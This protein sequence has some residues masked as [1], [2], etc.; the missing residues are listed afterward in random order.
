MPETKVFLYFDFNYVC[1]LC[2]YIVS[3]HQND[4]AEKILAF[5]TTRLQSWLDILE[6]PL[7][8][9]NGQLY[10]FDNRVTCVDLCVFNSVFS[11][12]EYLG[13]YYQRYVVDTHPVLVE[14][15]ARIGK[16]AN[17]AKLVKRQKDEGLVCWPAEL[18]NFHICAKVKKVLDEA[19]MGNKTKN[20]NTA[21]VVDGNIND[22][23]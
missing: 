6:K 23:D 12:V 14:H 22:I 4:S 21:D 3:T 9:S 15:Y 1:L 17:I 10:Y 16:R 18:N 5:V 2:M 20:E 7:T 11:M 19:H 8:Q 13:E